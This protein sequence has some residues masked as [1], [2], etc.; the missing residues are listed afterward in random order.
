MLGKNIT[1]FHYDA[2]PCKCAELNTLFS[3]IYCSKFDIVH[4]ITQNILKTASNDVY[5]VPLRM[6]R[7]GPNMW[8]LI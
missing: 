2:M 6:A 3:N 4:N 7:N 1:N 5:I 8:V